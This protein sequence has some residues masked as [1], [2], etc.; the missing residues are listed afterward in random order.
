MRW[1]RWM[2]WW[3]QFVMIFQ[4]HLL[5]QLDEEGLVPS[6]QVLHFLPAKH[7]L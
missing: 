3:F 2:R 6:K 5:P 1:M 7:S 4:V